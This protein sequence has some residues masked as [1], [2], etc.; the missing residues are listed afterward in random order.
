[1]ICNNCYRKGIN[2]ECEY[3]ISRYSCKVLSRL[4]TLAFNREYGHDDELTIVMNK[5]VSDDQWICTVPTVDAKFIILGWYKNKLCI[6][7]ASIL[8]ETDMKELTCED[9]IEFV[10]YTDMELNDD[11]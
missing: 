2:R 3:A 1:M 7:N 5:H 10:E 4:S 6:E 8:D 9:V 11:M